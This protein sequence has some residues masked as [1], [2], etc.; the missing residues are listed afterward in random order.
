MKE[1]VTTKPN[2]HRKLNK[3]AKVSA[4][5]EELKERM[6]SDNCFIDDVHIAADTMILSY[7]PRTLKKPTTT[8]IPTQTSNSTLRIFLRYL[9]SINNYYSSHNLD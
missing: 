5:Y 8:M 9:F 3:N 4:D 2:S 7:P 6:I 1:E